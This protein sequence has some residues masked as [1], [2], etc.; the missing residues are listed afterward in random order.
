[1]HN[2]GSF[3]LLL[4]LLV[5][6]FIIAL[7]YYDA[8]PGNNSS[9]SWVFLDSIKFQP[10]KVAIPPEGTLLTDPAP[11]Q[12]TSYKKQNSANNTV[13]Y[14]PAA[15]SPSTTPVQNL[16]ELIN[17]ILPEPL[18]DNPI[19]EVFE[20]EEIENEII[21]E[22]EVVITPITGLVWETPN[23][24]S[25]FTWD[26]G[27][28]F[29][30]PPSFSSSVSALF[31]PSPVPVIDSIIDEACPVTTTN[32]HM[33]IFNDPNC[34]YFVVEP[35]DYS[36][37][38]RVP[39]NISGTSDNP[40]VIFGAAGEYPWEISSNQRSRM[41]SFDIEASH[42]YIMYLEFYSELNPSST[43]GRGYSSGN[44][45]LSGDYNVFHGNYIR[46]SHRGC[47]CYGNYNTWQFSLSDDRP[48]VPF[49]VAGVGFYAKIG[50]ESRGNRVL[51]NEFIGYSDGVGLPRDATSIGSMPGTIVAY[52]TSWIPTSLHIETLVTDAVT[53]ESQIEVTACAEDGYDIKNGAL[54]N[55]ASDRSYFVYNT[56]RGHRVTDQSCGGSG[57]SGVG[58]LF[59]NWARNWDVAGN[60]S[61]DD[62]H[63]TY[64]KGTTNDGVHAVERVN[65]YKNVFAHLP[66]TNAGGMNG[67]RVSE[68]DGLAL[69]I[70]CENNCTVDQ[71]II[72]DVNFDSV[73]SEDESDTPITNNTLA[74]VINRK[75]LNQTYLDPAQTITLQI[76]K[77][78][79]KNPGATISMPIITAP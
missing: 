33:E 50:E 5:L 42:V 64:V 36:E 70:A 6:S 52:N 72:F 34:Q 27:D 69:R 10:Q 28:V 79:L 63:G 51:Y 37:Y 44:R 74:D 66:Q 61:Y 21:E 49:D 18:T 25:N 32:F 30:N 31:E 60:I 53:G 3:I 11:T 23:P 9:T 46:N 77:S 45:Q 15:P 75:L 26:P 8:L 39:L 78:P 2:R 41:D 13:T 24:G 40:R 17:E 14:T 43:G 71:N 59:H 19:V 22:E 4:L 62:A 29:A 55:S 76:A 73:W 16:G 38:E 68:N 65:M 56:T 67:D 48:E 57:S 47:R 54:S 35:G 12:K 7:D 20:E 1:M 58:W